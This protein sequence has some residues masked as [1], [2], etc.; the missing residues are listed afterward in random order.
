[1]MQRKVIKRTPA[2]ILQAPNPEPSGAKIIALMNFKGGVGKT[3]VAVNL[4]ATL[5]HKYNL[6][7]LLVDLD[8]QCSTTLWLLPRATWMELCKDKKTVWRIF[9]NA[10]QGSISGTENLIH[11]TSEL[12]GRSIDLLPATIEMLQAE[13][14]LTP[15]NPGYY[16]HL[17]EYIWP[18][19]DQYDFILLDCPPA[20]S[21]LTKNALFAADSI[22]VPYLP[23][24]LSLPG[25]QWLARLNREFQN[26]IQ[27]SKPQL[28]TA[29]IRG[30]VF[31]AFQKGLNIGTESMAE[32]RETLDQLIQLQLISPKVEI[33]QPIIPRDTKLAQAAGELQP[34]TIF[35]PNSP[36]AKAFEELA[37][38]AIRSLRSS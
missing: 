22:F 15:K 37:G 23:D 32:L 27:A 35:A 36:G 21:V 2:P 20:F 12:D 34:I 5:R 4:A 7:V 30:I 6:R 9:A 19:R 3:T 24:F 13:I 11:P 17:G 18:L 33:M 14:S 25:L 29:E 28:R 1:M 26:Q 38:N 8:P 31:N 10:I 16:K